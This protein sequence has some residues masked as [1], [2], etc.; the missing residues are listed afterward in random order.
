MVH[1]VKLTD[2]CC[3]SMHG[4]AT[5]YSINMQVQGHARQ[6]KQPWVM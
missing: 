5:L 2:N 6:A 1:I 4:Y 3:Q